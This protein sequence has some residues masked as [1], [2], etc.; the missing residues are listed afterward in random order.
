MITHPKTLLIIRPE[1]R[2]AA[3]LAVCAQYGWQGVPFAP[4]AMVPQTQTVF[5]LPENMARAAAVFWVSPSAVDIGATA[6][7]GSL[8]NLTVPHIAV[9]KATA[10]RLHDL[11]AKQV[12][13]AENGNDS[14]AVLRLPIWTNLPEKSEVLIVRGVGGRDFLAQQLTARGLMVRIAEIYQ[15]VPQTLDWSVFQAALPCAAWVT[16]GEVARAFWAQMPPKLAQNGHSL[17]Y[18]THHERVCAV[19][20]ELGAKNVQ[21]VSDLRQLLQFLND[22]FEH[23][24]S[25]DV[26]RSQ[27]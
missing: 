5:R 6:F 4:V 20:R 1:A 23:S 7:S 10:Q 26:K 16:S 8:N 25:S 27:T 13:Y 14:E 17:L 19:L 22:F 24:F 11:G 9:G 2:Q 12:L 18:F 15:R 21:Q 3:D